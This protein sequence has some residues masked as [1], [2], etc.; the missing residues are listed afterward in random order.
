[1]WLLW[2]TTL[3]VWWMAGVSE[4]IPFLMWWVDLGWLPDAHQAAL[5]LPLNWTGGE[6]I[7]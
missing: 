6:T 5:S 3:Y 4:K 2:R 1:M 7:R